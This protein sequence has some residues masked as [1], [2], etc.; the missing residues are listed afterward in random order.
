MEIPP[1]TAISLDITQDIAWITLNRPPL[2]ILTLEIIREL[3]SA[4]NEVIEQTNL[5]TVVLAAKGKAFCAGVD[6]ADHTPD[7]VE[8]MIREF[9]QLFT[10]LRTL[11]MPTI[12]LVQGAA[13]GGG[14]E[15]A[16]ACDLVIAAE[17][18]K[19]GQPEIKL[20]VF[21]PIA[22]ALFPQLIGHQQ[23]SRLLFSGETI[24]AAEA[25]RLGLATYLAAD[26]DLQATLDRL[27]T[28]YRSMSAA[29]LRITKRAILYGNDLGVNALL[30]I[31]D[32]Y[33][34][35]LMETA[36]AHEGIQAFMEKRQPRWS[37]K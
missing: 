7:R 25:V 6:V 23:T 10:R 2:N 8:P 27:L 34:R 13:L 15:L 33:L 21:P 12:A 17:S 14:C 16:I 35:D 30:E 5:K 20:G 36:D 3:D 4:L 24:N 37:D 18:A 32:L 22:A 11:P 29:A 31:E 9:G 1:L 26:D 28:Q 19:F